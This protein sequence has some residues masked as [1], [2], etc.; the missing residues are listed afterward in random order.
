V[1]QLQIKDRRRKREQERRRAQ[2]QVERHRLTV[3]QPPIM[4]VEE[5]ETILA[6][7]PGN[8]HVLE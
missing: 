7:H 4:D 8:P 3:G 2:W 6:F 1:T 5:A